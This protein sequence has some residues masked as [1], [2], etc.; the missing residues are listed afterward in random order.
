MPAAP[1]I[2][3]IFFILRQ[4]KVD[5]LCKEHTTG[6]V[7]NEC[8]KAECKNDKS[9]PFKEILIIHLR[10]NGE[11]EQYCDNICKRILRSLR[12]RIKHSA[13]TN[14]VAEHQEA[15]KRKADCG[16]TTPATIVI[17]I[18]NKIFVSFV[19]SPG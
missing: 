8:N 5:E 11:A 1:I 4:E 9:V 17:T 13:L 18:G 16:A 14:K 6:S 12:K 2:G 10:S 3:L 19:T 7:E 15:Y